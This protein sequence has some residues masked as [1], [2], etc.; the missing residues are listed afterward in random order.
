MITRPFALHRFIAGIVAAV[1]LP[2]CTSPTDAPRAMHPQSIVLLVTPKMLPDFDNPEVA[3]A[4]FFEHYKPLTSHAAETIVI[5]AVGNSD[6]M[7]NYRGAEYWSD[8]IEWA[9]TTDFVVVSERTLD[10][11]QI[12][13]IVSAFRNGATSAGIKL[14]VYD[15]I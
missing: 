5:F 8:A 2:S 6:H 12:K 7:L 10:Y 3:V 1:V 15:Q 4:Q 11:Y 9:R 13:R 14:K